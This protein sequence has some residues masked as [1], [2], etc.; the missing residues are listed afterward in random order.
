MI[1]TPRMVLIPASVVT[2]QADLA[3]PEALGRALGTAVAESWPP[4][5]YDD[6]AAKWMLGGLQATAPG[7]EGFWAYYF[8]WSTGP[9]GAVLIGVGGF[10]GPPAEGRVEL[11]YS[12]VPE[13]QRRGFATEAVL[14]MLRFAFSH[15]EVSEVIAETLPDLIPSIGV[16]EKTGFGLVGAGSEEG[17]VRYA[18]S[19]GAWAGGP[20]T[21]PRA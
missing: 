18:I 11:G 16:L 19:R 2:L 3:G 15:E 1:H 4:D 7:T 8:V 9:R 20:T 10:K 21:S 6:D 14:G 17:V 5:L 12:I 13:Y